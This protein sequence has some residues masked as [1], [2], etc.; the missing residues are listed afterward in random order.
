MGCAQSI[1]DKVAVEKSRQI[2]RN[3]QME[4]ARRTKEVKLLLLGAGE[5]GKSTIVKQMKIIHENGYGESECQNYR[6]VV[7]NNTIQSMMAIIRAMG[8]L[9][10]DF[11]TKQRAEDARHFFQ[12]CSQ[13]HEG[14]MTPELAMTMKRLWLD[15]GVQECYSRSQ[16]YQLNDSAY[17]YLSSLDRLANPNY[18]PNQQDVLRTRVKTSG[19]IETHFVYKGK[20]WYS[21][22]VVERKILLKV[23]IGLIYYR[24][25][26]THTLHI[27]GLEILGFLAPITS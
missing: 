21:A 25:L 18:I 8:H 3:L 17:Y 12:I 10:I 20:V 26:L 15:A 24:I 22:V 2:D 14:E 9:R 6:S 11:V 4:E 13:L 7:F 19:I 23:Y 27:C 16:E 1:D 5:S